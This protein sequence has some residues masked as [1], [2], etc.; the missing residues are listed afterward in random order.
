MS[1]GSYRST[2]GLESAVEAMKRGAFTYLT[3]PFDSRE[4]ILQIERARERSQLTGEIIR[5]KELLGE[6]FNFANIIAK[7]EPTNIALIVSSGIILSAG[8]KDL[9]FSLDDI[10]YYQS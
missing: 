9:K 2:T 10:V 4:L 3:K 7:S 5:L 8:I 6:R 1:G